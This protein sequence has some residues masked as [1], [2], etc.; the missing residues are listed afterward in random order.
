MKKINDKKKHQEQQKRNPRQQKRQVLRQW[1]HLLLRFL[2][3]KA[4]LGNRSWKEK[5]S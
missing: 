4:K 3:Y 1:L 2:E 5:E